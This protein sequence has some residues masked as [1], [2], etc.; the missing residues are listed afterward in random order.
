[1]SRSPE[2][3]H[4]PETRGSHDL[5]QDARRIFLASLSAVDPR[6]LTVKA[7]Q[8]EG[9]Q[10][11]FGPDTHALHGNV[12][13]AAFGKAALGMVR[14]VEEVLGEHIV[15][16]HATI[17]AG[18]LEA[19]GRTRPDLLPDKDSQV[20]ITEGAISNL[21]DPEAMEG[22][23][24][25]LQLA[26]EGT[27][28]E[29]FI[30][31]VS[32][33]G[34]ALLP[35]PAGDLALKDKCLAIQLLSK[36]GATINELNTVRKHLSAIKGGWL[37]KAAAPAR[38]LTLIL[39]DVIDDPLDI[40][41]SGPTVP[42]PSTYGDCLA[43]IRKLDVEEQFPEPVLAHLAR[44]ARC[45]ILETPEPGDPDFAIARNLIIGNHMLAVKS[46]A[47][48]ARELGYTTRLGSTGVRG[49]SCRAGRELAALARVLVN[50]DTA[51]N[52]QA[53]NAQANNAQTNNTPV[54]KARRC[55]ISA[56]E[57]TVRVTG[58]G[59]GGRCQEVALSAAIEMDGLQDVF[60]LCGG[61][62]GQDGPTDVAGAFADGQTLARARTKDLDARRFLE[63]NDSYYLFD[64]LG[65]HLRTGPTGT[66]VMDLH[67]LLLV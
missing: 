28:D 38:V 27:A 4:D 8:R 55:V 49:D 35:L 32:G 67:I 46:A 23:R 39:S 2:V 18:S 51:N 15:A 7:L 14:G 6:R 50:G 31:C 45:A 10:L 13:L 56:G 36:A 53:N 26:R 40:I 60:L 59:Q 30:V 9:D 33:G 64:E 21:P 19:L 61:T 12:K 5:R 58:Q 1:M 20:L 43:I 47:R 66:N 34:S 29:L 57:T 44:G 42:D 17:P 11:R 48:K 25:I 3:Q 62:D 24:R 41:A 37:A 63:N 52:A 22:A 16:G 54:G 65:D